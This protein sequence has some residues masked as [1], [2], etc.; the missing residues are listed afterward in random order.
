MSTHG[1]PDPYVA[2]R[3]EERSATIPPVPTSRKHRRWRI[4]LIVLGALVLTRIALPYVLL[5]FANKR[6]AS[7]PDYY[8]HIADLDLALIRGAYAVE[9]FSLEKKDSVSQ[10]LTPFMSADAI[11][12]SVEWKA[13]FDGSIVGELVIEH[14]ELRFT[15]EAAEP[16]AALKDTADFR[17][18]LKD[19]MPLKVNRVE[20]HGG[21]IRYIDIGSSPRVDVQM[22]AVEALVLNLTNSA[23]PSKLL[24]STLRATAKVYGGDLTFNMGLAPL[25]DNTRFDMNVEL[26]HTDLKRIN[27]LFKAYANFDVN[28]GTFGLYAEMATRDGAFKGYVKPLIK[29]LDVVGPEDKNDGLFHKLWEA[30]VGAAGGLLKN[31]GTDNVATKVT[32][33]GRLDQPK[34][35]AWGAIVQSVRNAFIEALPSTLDNEINIATVG[36]KAPEE[37][38]GFLRKLFGKKDKEVP[39]D[40]K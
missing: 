24:P 31:P 26:V 30:V 10:K 18:L 4:A 27:D 28:K 9:S 38:K 39:K 11:D 34:V 15:K 13:L 32:F 19:F 25:A 1:S 5:H 17:S 35:G 16:A 37:K 6:L 7:M 40:R 20:V 8:G 36:H 21:V 14:P 29:D 3:E 12:L 33:E 23:D 22:D 2:L